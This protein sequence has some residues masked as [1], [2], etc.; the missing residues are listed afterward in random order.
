MLDRAK[1]LRNG[2]TPFEAMLWRHL[3]RSQLRGY[4]FRRQHVIGNCIADFFCP[5]KGLIVEVDGDTHD[6]GRDAVRGAINLLFGYETIRFSNVDV[7]KNIEGVLAAILIRLESLPD[8]WPHP[9]IPSPKGEG[10]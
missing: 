9:S 3:S 8:C 1:R 2:S 4:K 7:G 5:P 10:K 6:P